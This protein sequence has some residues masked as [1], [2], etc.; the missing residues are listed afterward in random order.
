LVGP[1]PPGRTSI[2]STKL[3]RPGFRPAALIFTTE[4]SFA[5]AGALIEVAAIARPGVVRQYATTSADLS[6]VRRDNFVV[7][8]VM[9]RSISS[10]A[11]TR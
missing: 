2:A 4:P 9:A 3:Y 1:A 8:Q 5:V 7:I 11:R 6:R 10:A